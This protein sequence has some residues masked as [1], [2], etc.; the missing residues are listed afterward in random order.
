MN[1]GL[2][3]DTVVVSELRKGMRAEPAV[4][5]WRVAVAAIP[6]FLSVITLLEIR[7]GL[8]RVQARDPAFAARLDAWLSRKTPS[9]FSRTLAGRGSSRG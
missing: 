8:R 5:D 2:L 7:L 1:A 4:V 9:A 3:L 6:T